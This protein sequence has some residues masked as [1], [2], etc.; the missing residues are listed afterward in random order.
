MHSRRVSSE[1]KTKEPQVGYN[2]TG[3]HVEAPERE[4]E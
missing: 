4:L 1:M 3:V 2:G